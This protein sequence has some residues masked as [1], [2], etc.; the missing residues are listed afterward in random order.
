MQCC[1]CG[2]VH[3]PACICNYIHVIVHT[4]TLTVSDMCAYLR[5]TTC[6]YS[7]RLYSYTESQQYT[8]I[9]I[10]LCP[11]HTYWTPNGTKRWTIWHICNNMLSFSITAK[12]HHWSDGLENPLWPMLKITIFCGGC[13][14]NVLYVQ[15]TNNNQRRQS[16]YLVR[17]LKNK[18]H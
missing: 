12:E 17:C 2:S 7:A 8:C 1:T 6:T 18:L 5:H 3:N 14:C 13:L 9:K 16:Q 4:P 10:V 15:Y 11:P